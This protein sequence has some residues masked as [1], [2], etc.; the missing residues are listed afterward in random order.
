MILTGAILPILFAAAALPQQQASPP[1]DPTPVARR[2]AATAQLAAQEYRAGVVDGRVVAKAEVE[3][4]TLF[5]QEARRSAALLPA[6]AGRPATADIDAMLHLVGATARPDSLDARVRSLGDGLTRRLGITLDELPAVTPSLSRGAEVYQA[7][8]AGCHGT[9][10]RGDGPLAAGLTPP[11]ANLA[12]GPALRDASPLDYF[13]RISI[14]TV[15]TAM[16][17]FEGRLPAEDRWAAALYATVLRLPAPRGDVPPALRAFPASGRMSDQE[18]LAAL[19][20][21]DA[22]EP[23]ARGRLAAVRTFQADHTEAATAQVFGQVRRQLDSA[24]ALAR[25]GDPTASARAFDAYMTFEQVERGVRAK[26]PAL[27]S[28]LETAFASLRTRAAGGAT[29]AELTALRRQLNAGL[30]N[31]ERVLGDRDSPVNLFV[32]SF[33][34]LLREG[35]EAILIVGAL[36]T[37]LSKMGAGH[38]KRDI[39]IGVG[40]AVGASLVTAVVLETIFVLSPAHREALEGGTMVLATAV[41][42]YVS[43]WLL[44]KMEVVKWNHFVKSK[45]QDALDS[46]SALALASAAFLAVYREGF[47]TVLFYK[48][49]FVAGAGGTMPVLAGI[50]AGSVVLVGV[51]IAINR[52]GVRLPLKP[53]FAITSA[54]LYYMAFVFAGK[55]IAELQE[56]DLIG[57]TILSWAPRVPALGIYPTVESLGAQAV[58][59]MLAIVALVWTFVVEPRRARGV[60]AA[61]MAPG[62]RPRVSAP[63]AATQARVPAESVSAAAVVELLRS[64]ERMEADLAEMR[65]EVERMRRHLCADTTAQVQ[66]PPR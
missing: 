12:D 58:L 5:L 43:Y 23:A 33:I 39:H 50:V 18:V 40:A 52:F 41:L 46:G 28:E 49:L 16:P 38:R 26:S 2:V 34:I 44:S 17:A 21:A 36:M 37:F 47:E 13:R 54:F 25:A 63:V 11:P 57:T 61:A 15:G 19:G 51:Y 31:A 8:C 64:L 3:E 32:Q 22:S 53:F 30:E 4:A 59:V 29:P 65:A 9:I 20:V 7:N 42:F 24:F 1:K 60:A 10:G 6:E 62:R 45:V 48:A 55:G 56:G 66:R 27:A 14:G 35:L